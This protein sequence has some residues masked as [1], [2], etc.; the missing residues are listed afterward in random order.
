[1]VDEATTMRCENLSCLCE[2]AA[3]DATCSDYCA[4]PSG[5]DALDVRCNCGHP[6]CAETI[7]KQLSG[8]AGR[9][10]A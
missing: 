2:V 6:I 7:E 5:R 4:S 9:E 3:S 8:E 10:T 1:M